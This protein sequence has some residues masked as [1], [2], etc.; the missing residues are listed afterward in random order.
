MLHASRARTSKVRVVLPRQICAL[1]L[2]QITPQLLNDSSSI[3]RKKQIWEQ[4]IKSLNYDISIKHRWRGKLFHHRRLPSQLFNQWRSPAKGALPC[5]VCY[6]VQSPTLRAELQLGIPENI[7]YYLS[8]QLHV[9]VSTLL[10]T[11][12]WEPVQLSTGFMC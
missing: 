5:L 2:Y 7:F 10:C 1:F 12:A 4:L 8:L 3:V 9:S 11:F 6:F